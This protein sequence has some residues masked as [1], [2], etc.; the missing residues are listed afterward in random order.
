[1]I[2]K[3]EVIE[4]QPKPPDNNLNVEDM[5]KE[6]V[7]KVDDNVSDFDVTMQQEDEEV[8]DDIEYLE[9]EVSSV[10]FLEVFL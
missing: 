6:D 9:N 10:L 1:M 7:E 3:L 8:Y 5:V 4:V 2:L